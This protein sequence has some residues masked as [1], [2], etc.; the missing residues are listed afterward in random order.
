[1]KYPTDTK[2]IKIFLPIGEKRFE[3]AGLRSIIYI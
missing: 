3:T 2:D 1:M